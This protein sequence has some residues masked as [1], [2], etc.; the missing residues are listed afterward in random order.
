MNQVKCEGTK[1]ALLDSPKGDSLFASY[2][3]REMK[4]GKMLIVASCDYL[5]TPAP[6]F[7]RT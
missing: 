2:D 3:P 1:Y 7:D 5:Y 4:L 6:Y